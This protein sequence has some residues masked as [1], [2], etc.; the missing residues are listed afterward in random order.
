MERH[1][2]VGVS[3]IVAL[4]AAHRDASG[5]QEPQVTFSQA[6]VSRIEAR[7]VEP[8]Y[9]AGYDELRDRVASSSH[10]QRRRQTI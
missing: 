3:T 4:M 2:S 1:F 9:L 8:V 5:R 6:T 10:L 7:L